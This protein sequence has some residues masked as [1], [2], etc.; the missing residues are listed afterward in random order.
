MTK[1]LLTGRLLHASSEG[2]ADLYYA[3]GFNAPD[4]FFWFE[5]G[6]QRGIVV[7]PLEYSRALKEAKSGVEVISSVQLLA[8]D[9]V[10]KSVPEALCRRFQITRWMVPPDFPFGTAALLG[11]CGAEVEL[12]GGEFFPKR[13]KKTSA[14][15]QHVARAEEVTQEAMLLVHD[16]LASSVVNARGQLVMA[17]RL[18]TS[19]WVREEVEVFFKRKGF[20]ASRTIVACGRQGADPHN[21]GTGPIVANEPVVADLFPRDDRSGYWGDMTRTFVKGKASPLVNKAYCA[22]RKAS[23]CAM[24]ML[25]EGVSPAEVHEAALE[26]MTSDG[27]YTG[28]DQE[29]RPC[30]F[31]HGLGHG[32]GLQIH[33]TP[34]V[35]PRN[36]V[37]LAAGNLVSVEPGLY[38]AEWG[39]IRLEDLVVITKDSYRNLCSMQKELEI[40]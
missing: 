6:G 36:Q 15:I 4:P 29:G 31:F 12:Y 5:A 1:K 22:V 39:G 14:E 30:G 16:M 9:G 10:A 25:R 18:L 8:S 38:Y 11:Q 13:R 33:E 24:E 20:S 21:I 32:V 17:R 34:S 28:L 40:I 23:Q 3:S 26:S 35:S 27:F 2:S 19:E 7:S 37:P